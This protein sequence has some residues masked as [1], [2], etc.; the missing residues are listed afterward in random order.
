MKK[1]IITF[2]ALVAISCVSK[3]QYESAQYQA[4]Y[5]EDAYYNLNEEF[6]KANRKNQQLINEYNKLVE[7]YNDLNNRINRAKSAVNDLDSHFDYFIR[8]SWYDADDIKSDIS[9][10]KSKLNGW[11]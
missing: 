5:W 6:G 1:L 9:D 3:D 4:E 8:G 2:F 11:L 10:I 7:E